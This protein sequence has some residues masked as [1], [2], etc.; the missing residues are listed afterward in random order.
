V[1]AVHEVAA[2]QVDVVVPAAYGRSGGRDADTTG[3][4]DGL[5]PFFEFHGYGHFVLGN[6]GGS[7]GHPVVVSVS[8][9]EIRD[10]PGRVDMGPG[11]LHVGVPGQGVVV[12]P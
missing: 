7:E 12:R 10:L 8:A 3:T 2:G 11:T 4:P 6:V 5:S 9:D 1:V